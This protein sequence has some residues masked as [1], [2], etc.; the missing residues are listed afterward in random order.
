M[1][2]YQNPKDLFPFFST[3][4][5]KNC[6]YFDNAEMSLLPEPVICKIN[7]SIIKPLKQA[8]ISSLRARMASMLG[9]NSEDLFFG[10]GANVCMERIVRLLDLQDRRNYAIDPLS[11]KSVTNPINF[12]VT[13]KRACLSLLSLDQNYRVDPDKLLQSIDSETSCIIVNQVSNF[14]GL[15][16][17]VKQLY[18]NLQRINDSENQ[19]IL[20]I[21][22]A[23]QG[24]SRCKSL[25]QADIVFFSSE[26]G[27]SLPGAITL[28]SD[29]AKRILSGSNDLIQAQLFLEE[30]YSGGI[31]HN[32]A[33]A[34]M[35]ETQSF[36]QDMDD[37][38]YIKGFNRLQH[39]EALT[40]SLFS[41]LSGIDGL[42][43]I[44]LNEHNLRFN[45]GIIS[46]CLPNDDLVRINSE[47]K[48]YGVFTRFAEQHNS[49]RFYC[50]SN[51]QQIFPELKEWNSSLRISLHWYNDH[52]DIR[53]FMNLF[54]RY[55]K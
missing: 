50:M 49:N 26:K 14:T 22:D 8:K 32:A 28:F 37:G 21:V 16:Q 25:P 2:Q 43:L 17:P 24:F 12:M 3:E 20:L 39:L 19:D 33:I 42:T 4:D 55:L 47:L 44:G 36:I 45:R 40:R 13:Q 54:K 34:S 46:F 10:P 31:P 41:E 9:K 48:H 52:T 51:F 18:E 27:L 30:F 11:G 15:E 29:R 7:E 38:I 5:G 35:V 23:S 1:H 53:R 6:I